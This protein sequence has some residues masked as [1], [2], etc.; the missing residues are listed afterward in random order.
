M[1]CIRIKGG[2]TTIHSIINMQKNI[3]WPKATKC[4]IRISLRAKM[5][6]PKAPRG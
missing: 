1:V 2:L 4:K 5:S 6:L 3:K